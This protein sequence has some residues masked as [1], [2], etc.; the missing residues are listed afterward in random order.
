MKGIAILLTALLAACSSAGSGD[1]AAPA[2]AP[3]GLSTNASAA[4][5]A[6]PAGITFES[7]APRSVTVTQADY[8]GVFSERNTCNPFA[9]EIA[10]VKRSASGSGSATYTVTPEGAGT[11][12]I[13][14]SNVAGKAVRI[15]VKVTTAAVTVH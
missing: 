2:A 5:H 12:A 4:P 10:A 9:G 6:D 14:V 7:A 13:T 1:L 3:L 8:K 15:S 11:C